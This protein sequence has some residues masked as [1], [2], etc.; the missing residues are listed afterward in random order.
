MFLWVRFIKSCTGRKGRGALFVF[1][2]VRANLESLLFVNVLLRA[3]KICTTANK[4]TP[5]KSSQPVSTGQRSAID[6]CSTQ[7][8]LHMSQEADSSLLLLS[9]L[10]PPFPSSVHLSFLPPQSPDCLALV[11]SLAEQAGTF[12]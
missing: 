10:K 6:D 2:K 9:L 7:T 4:Q 5:A 3:V 12:H 11:R 1:D 8:L